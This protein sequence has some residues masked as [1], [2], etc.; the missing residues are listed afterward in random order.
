MFDPVHNC[1]AGGVWE[2]VEA[3]QQPGGDD[4]AQLGS[5]FFFWERGDYYIWSGK[6]AA[7]LVRDVNKP[8][9]DVVCELARAMFALLLFGLF[10]LSGWYKNVSRAAQNDY[11]FYDLLSFKL[12]S[13]NITCFLYFHNLSALKTG[14]AG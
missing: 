8:A 4:W 3:N 12:S 9:V 11:L 10:S 1:D 13:E 5:G 6:Q 14:N 2:A 7:D